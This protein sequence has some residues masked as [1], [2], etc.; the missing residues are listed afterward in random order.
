MQ[1]SR[2]LAALGL[3]ITLGA[4]EST[5]QTLVETDQKLQA[6]FGT[7]TPNQSGQGHESSS[8]TT[9]ERLYR[10]ALAHKER[11]ETKEALNALRRAAELGHGG[12][13]FELGESYRRGVGVEENLSA[14]ARY[15]GEAAVADH[16]GGQYRLA[17]AFA[18]GHGVERDLS[19]AMRWYGKAAYQG[20][21]K[22]QFAYGVLLATGKGLAKNEQQA[23]GWLML[24][25]K[26]GIRR[27][28]SIRQNIEKKITAQRRADANLWVKN[29]RPIGGDA[30]TDP[31]TVKYV[32]HQ[33]AEL[34]YNPGPE[35]G[36]LGPQSRTAVDEFQRDQ[37][38][39]ANG[40]I[41]AQLLEQLLLEG[42]Q[43]RTR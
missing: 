43:R 28:S 22:A 38:L 37:G 21:A 2:S 26:N 12:A 42:R 39:L 34:G 35:D 7:D 17:E 1:I 15:Y 30:V 16:A 20:H 23:Y 3:A 24:A 32:Q 27:A 33:L 25:E 14:A 13:A 40:T 36:I 6:F 8:Y 41:D 5:K 31:P 19:W 9:A 4:C 11:G 18:D 29:F 10:D